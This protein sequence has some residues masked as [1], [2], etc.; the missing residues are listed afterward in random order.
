LRQRLTPRRLDHGQRVTEPGGTEVDRL[1]EFGHACVDDGAQL[2]DPLSLAGIVGDELCQPIEL[3]VEPGFRAVIGIA[4]ALI[5]G[6]EIATL[7][8]FGFDHRGLD[9]GELQQD[10]VRMLHPAEALL[11]ANQIEIEKEDRRQKKRKRDDDGGDARQRAHRKRQPLTPVSLHA[12]PAT[13]KDARSPWR[14]MAEGPREMQGRV[15]PERRSV[16]RCRVGGSAME[17]C[18]ST[19]TA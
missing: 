18:L 8:R 3:S 5:A 17:M 4:I 16:S 1:L 19:K 15:A 6:E 14:R 10:L 12:R 11:E 7:G 9:G 2:L 13:V